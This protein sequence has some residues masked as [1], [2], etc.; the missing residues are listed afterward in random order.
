MEDAMKARLAVAG[1]RSSPLARRPGGGAAR[2]KPCCGRA[3]R[4]RARPSRQRPGR[5]AGRRGQ[6]PE[7]R[8]RPSTV[9]PDEVFPQASSIKLAVLYELYRQ[10]GRRARSTSPRRRAPP[11][12]GS[13]GGVLQEL[14]DRVSLT[15]RD[16]AVLMVGWSDNEATNVLIDRVGMD[17]V[18]RRLDGRAGLRPHAAAP[19]DDGPGRGPPRRRERVHALGDAAAGGDDLRRARASPPPWRADIRAVLAVAKDS[20][21]RVPLPETATIMDKPGSL[22]GVYCVTAVVDLPGRPYAVSIETTFLGARRTARPPSG[23]SR[24]RSTRPSTGCRGR[25]SWAG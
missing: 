5:R 7:V 19:Q 4:A 16:L 8:A 15:W 12:R 11:C 22:E 17:A 18:N 9:R 6:G 20:T 13:G 10:A 1:P 14:G 3:A 25:A 23:R 24:P 2:R 21:F